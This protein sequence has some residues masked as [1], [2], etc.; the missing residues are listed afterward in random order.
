MSGEETDP[1][2]LANLARGNLR[3]KQVQLAQA[4]VGTVKD[5]HRFLLLQQITLIE[6]LEQ[7]IALF[8]REIA[9]RIGRDDE[10]MEGEQPPSQEPQ[11]ASS[12]SRPE[13]S[14]EQEDEAPSFPVTRRGLEGYAKALE[15]LDEITRI[16]RRVAEIILAEIGINMDQFPSDG[17][18]ASW[19]GMRP[20]S[21]VGAGKRLSG[22]TTKGSPW[23]R[24]ALVEAAHGAAH[25]KG[26]Y[27]GEQYRR[28][29]RRSGRKFLGDAQ[30]RMSGKKHISHKKR[31]KNG[32]I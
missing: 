11:R 16:N 4:M 22:K 31:G 29:A 10:E 17:H 12:S 6:T 18:L 20:S 30:R 28:L 24:A 7:Q 32:G 15:R 1:G 2:E 26:T 25:S 27:L 8:D 21:K 13:G 9:D 14:S 23:L 3:G 5:H 19:A